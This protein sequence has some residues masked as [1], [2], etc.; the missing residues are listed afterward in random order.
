[1]TAREVL[2]VLT[3]LGCV[4]LRQKGSHIRVVSPRGKCHTTVPNHAGERLGVGL[5]KA[6]QRQMAP[7]LG[8]GWLGV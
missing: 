1:M 3:T 6:I 8:P 2:R 7:C 5:L 4:V